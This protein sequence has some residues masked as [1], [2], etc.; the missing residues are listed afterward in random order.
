M[1]VMEAVRLVRTGKLPMPALWQIATRP[2][3]VQVALILGLPAELPARA[4]S[5]DL[6]WKSMNT[7]QRRLVLRHAPPSITRRLPSD[8]AIGRRT[9]WRRYT[10]DAVAPGLT[11]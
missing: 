5:P 9:V 7:Q 4:A 11:G 1:R 6:A 8:P 10:V 3:R 2:E